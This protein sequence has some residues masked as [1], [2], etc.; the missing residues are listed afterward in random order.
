ML[1]SVLKTLKVNARRKALMAIALFALNTLSSCGSLE[2]WSEGLQAVGNS[3]SGAN[4]YM[5]YAPATKPAASS[6]IN[7]TQ[8][9]ITPTKSTAVSVE[10]E[11][12]YCSQCPFLKKV[13]SVLY[14]Y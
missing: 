1:F 14:I 4:Y 10:K 8:S 2:Q 13:D 12:H 7:T 5:P 6:Y 9:Y 11:W 3:L